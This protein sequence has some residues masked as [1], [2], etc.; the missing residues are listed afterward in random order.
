LIITWCDRHLTAVHALA[1]LMTD[2]PE[3]VAAALAEVLSA[4]QDA[5]VAPLARSRPDSGAQLMSRE[6]C[7]A[8]A[9]ALD[10]VEMA[11]GLMG[12]RTCATAARV[13][14]LPE[15]V[16][17]AR[18]LAALQALFTPCDHPGAEAPGST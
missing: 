3:V 8:Q 10:R 17:N 1:A 14:G 9:G 5:A 4:P 15:Y 12:D 16:V 18:L 11:L 7:P 2:T 13:L 6:Q